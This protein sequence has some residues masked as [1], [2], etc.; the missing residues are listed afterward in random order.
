MGVCVRYGK[1]QEVA[2]RNE[3]AGPWDTITD[4]TDAQVCIKDDHST[5]STS[6]ASQKHVEKKP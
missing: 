4:A 2:A 3:Q 5:D 1:E 6:G